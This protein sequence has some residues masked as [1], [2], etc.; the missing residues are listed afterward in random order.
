MESQFLYFCFMKYL[1]NLST[2]PHWNMAFDQYALEHIQAD[3]PLF[4]L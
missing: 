2:D 3:E 1:I 4:Y